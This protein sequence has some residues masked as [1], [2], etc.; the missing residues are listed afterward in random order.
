MHESTAAARGVQQQSIRYYMSLIICYLLHS[1]GKVKDPH[2]QTVIEG[3][4]LYCLSL[5]IL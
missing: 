2:I 1:Q 5:F 4:R 3:E